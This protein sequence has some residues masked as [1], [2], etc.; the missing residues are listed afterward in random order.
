VNTLQEFFKIKLPMLMGSVT[1]AVINQPDRAASSYYE[2]IVH[3]QAADE[4]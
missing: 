1:T 4:S 3:C 2:V